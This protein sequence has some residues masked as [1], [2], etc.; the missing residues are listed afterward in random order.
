M[1]TPLN[2]TQLATLTGLTQ[3]Q[4]R[5]RA[6][7]LTAQ[8]LA[9]RRSY[10]RQRTTYE[11]LESP[12]GKVQRLVIDDAPAAEFP[13]A[14]NSSRPAALAVALHKAGKRQDRTRLTLDMLKAGPVTIGQVAKHLGCCDATASS[15]LMELVKH[16][17]VKRI[18][19]SHRLLQ[20]QLI[21]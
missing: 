16:G 11:L 15:T 21:A 6:E 5:M 9:I 20:W 3:S 2:T 8:R 14:T 19:V 12:A 10:R 1:P 7:Y 4:A 13:R 17:Q 18:P